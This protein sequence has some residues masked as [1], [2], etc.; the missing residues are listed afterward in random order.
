MW[1]EKKYR[2]TALG[3][4]IIVILMV[5]CIVTSNP[6]LPGEPADIVLCL[7]D[8]AA[9]QKIQ[10]ER[11]HAAASLIDNLGDN[12]NVGGI[13]YQ[14]NVTSLYDIGSLA[15]EN[16]DFREAIRDFFDSA[17]HEDENPNA[18]MGKAINEAVDMIVNFREE[19]N[20]SND[21]IIL[22][23]TDGTNNF[24]SENG[25]KSEADVEEA[26]TLTEKAAKRAWEENIQVQ[27]VCYNEEFPKLIDEIKEDTGAG[28][29]FI[30]DI[31]RLEE[32]MLLI[33][34]PHVKTTQ[35]GKIGMEI[36]IVLLII[37]V[38]GVAGY[39]FH[40]YKK[41]EYIMDYE[42]SMM[43][44]E[45]LQK[46][47]KAELDAH[48]RKEQENK[49]FYLDVILT[50]GNAIGAR[51]CFDNDG[52][53]RTGILSIGD[54][55]M[56]GKNSRGDDYFYRIDEAGMEIWATFEEKELLLKSKQ[57]PF[58]IRSE[59]TPRDQGTKTQK[60]VLK[61]D[62]QYYIILGSKHEIGL[63]AQSN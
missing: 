21:A 28:F 59:G 17:V 36:L 25:E 40:N 54:I 7:D 4:V 26:D 18:N 27:F 30:N 51:S 53:R 34:N 23:L 10:E 49:K 32:T 31:K 52:R 38:A 8:S 37:G 48:I 16:T 13:F 61:A 20:S 1:K 46:E 62:Q 15:E 35:G 41:Q 19:K 58:E 11:N 47:K 57:T 63:W 42:V 2:I 22:V 60:A 12:V 45:K 39:Y 9:F 44:D 3:V 43:E 6:E 55:T 33:M 50:H 5:V 29:Y 24:Y 56:I 14:N